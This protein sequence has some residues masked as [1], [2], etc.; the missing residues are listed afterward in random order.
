LINWGDHTQSAGAVSSSGGAFS[1]SAPPGGHTYEMQGPVT[2][3]VHLTEVANG[4]ASST[5]TGTVE[6]AK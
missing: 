6:V 5:A 1:V 2:V 4:T 3:S